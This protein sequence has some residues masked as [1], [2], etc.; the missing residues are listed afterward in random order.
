M[1]MAHQH[2]NQLRPGQAMVYAS[3]F[4]DYPKNGGLPYSPEQTAAFNITSGVP[5]HLRRVVLQGRST[6]Q[7]LSRPS[8]PCQWLGNYTAYAMTLN[9]YLIAAAQ[10]MF[11][12]ELV[13]DMN[14]DGKID[15]TDVATVAKAFGSHPGSQTGNSRP[16]SPGRIPLV[17]DGRID[18][19]DVAPVAR[20]FGSL[21]DQTHDCFALKEEYH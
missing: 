10:T 19:S 8:R 9:G 7:Y 1:D 15:I 21:L 16:I 13:G 12:V 17:P 20:E 14:A 11:T 18:L 5:A 6:L 2:S 4:N 3:I